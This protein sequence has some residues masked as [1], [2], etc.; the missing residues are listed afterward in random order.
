MKNIDRLG[1]LAASSLVLGV[2]SFIA[3]SISPE[4]IDEQGVLHEYFF[5][6]PTGFFFIF[7]G[8]LLSMLW[9]YKQFRKKG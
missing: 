5:L 6:V 7:L 2:L 4:Y 1:V 8:L 3:R 9:F